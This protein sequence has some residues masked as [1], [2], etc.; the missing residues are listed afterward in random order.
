MRLHLC[1][2]NLTSSLVVT[3]GAFSGLENPAMKAT[4]VD[5]Y[6]IVA[7]RVGLHIKSQ[8]HQAIKILHNY[9]TAATNLEKD[10][11]T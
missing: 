5:V 6:D 4:S 8:E 11:T 10:N 2:L 1:H 7:S 9:L 3:A